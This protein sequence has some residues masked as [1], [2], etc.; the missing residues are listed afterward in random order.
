MEKILLMLLAVQGV[1][2]GID[3][4]LNHELLARLPQ[5]SEARLEVALH[6]CREFLY[7]SF[8]VSLAWWSWL[9]A[10]SL[11]P[12]VLLGLQIA[13]DAFDEAVENKT[14]VLP[15]NER[16]LHFAITV[17]LGLICASLVIV[18][19]NWSGQAT[20]LARVHHGIL[21]WTVSALGVAALLWSG[22]DFWAWRQL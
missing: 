17:N 1:L 5:R 9:G 14:R 20:A 18:L 10:W 16:L 19:W 8:F 22:R 11:L 3:T 21:S 4:L 2:G 15:Q 12:A 7:G 13:V 6:A